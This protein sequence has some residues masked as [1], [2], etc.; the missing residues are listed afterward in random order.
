MLQLNNLHRAQLHLQHNFLH[1]HVLRRRDRA[2]LLRRNRLPDSWQQQLLLFPEQPCLLQRRS[3]KRLMLPLRFI[4]RN[5]LRQ[6][7]P[8][9]MQ[10]FLPE[11]QLH[12]RHPLS[13]RQRPWLLHSH[14]SRPARLQL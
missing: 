10:L 13:L 2:A 5:V 1:V 12:L 9:L 14:R 7:Q 11:R 6:R 3:P 8:A 4:R